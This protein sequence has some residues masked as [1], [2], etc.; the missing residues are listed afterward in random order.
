VP[1][2]TMTST[3]RTHRLLTRIRRATGGLR[4]SKGALGFLAVVAVAVL[5]GNP[6]AIVRQLLTP[7]PP[8]V[9]SLDGIYP[10]SLEVQSARAPLWTK[11]LISAFGVRN[12]L[13]AEWIHWNVLRTNDL[14][15]R[16]AD[17]LVRMWLRD[18]KQRVT[19]SDLAGAWSLTS[20][21]S[22]ARNSASMYGRS[23]Y[24]ELL[25]DLAPDV[26][27]HAHTSGVPRAKEDAALSWH[28]DEAWRAVLHGDEGAAKRW[29]DG[30]LA[31]PDCGGMVAVT[32]PERSA[33][34]YAG[35]V[36]LFPHRRHF[37]PVM[38]GLAFLRERAPEAHDLVVK[39]TEVVYYLD[40]DAAPFNGAA[41]LD[42]TKQASTW[43]A[44]SAFS[45]VDTACWALLLYHEALHLQDHA[46]QR[47]PPT[48]KEAWD[49]SHLLVYPA[50]AE[51]ARQIAP[52]H[53]ERN[54][55]RAECAE[56]GRTSTGAACYSLSAL[57][58]YYERHPMYD[59]VQR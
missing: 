55:R 26:W 54:E 13:A 31:I 25:R 52:Q 59:T 47:P 37:Q 1:K 30:A 2:Q 46:E 38:A 24:W 40:D 58:E 39:Y 28:L 3:S 21:Q 56:Y 57:V 33:C 32:N 15:Q 20:R 5:L 49:P 50:V 53:V 29:M 16:H 6:V 48:R 14:D 34:R 43:I 19:E 18:G 12:P 41:G 9:G 10:M 11:E 22:A 44:P 8:P 27:T 36:A 4:L 17:F 42:A 23:A 35:R 51:L 7:P 45:C